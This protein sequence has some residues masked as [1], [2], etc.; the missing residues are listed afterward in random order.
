M[1][2]TFEEVE[3]KDLED[4]EVLRYGPKVHVSIIAYK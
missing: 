2:F 3:L 4:V 1:L